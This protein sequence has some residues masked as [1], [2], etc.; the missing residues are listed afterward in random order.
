MRVRFTA[1]AR[2][3]VDAALAWLAE[4]NPAAAAKLA[5]RLEQVA[6]RLEAFPRAGPLKVEADIRAIPV[7]GFSYTLYYRIHSAT[8]EVVSLRHSARRP[9]TGVDFP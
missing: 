2:S 8:V 7:R 6:M 5:A 3:Q 9:P 1:E 4:R